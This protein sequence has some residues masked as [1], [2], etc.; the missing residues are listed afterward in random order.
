MQAEGSFGSCQFD[1]RSPTVE[2]VWTLINLPTM[3]KLGLHFHFLK[4]ANER[5]IK[6]VLFIPKVIRRR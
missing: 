3:P 6:V 1:I 4:F 5:Q 2:K